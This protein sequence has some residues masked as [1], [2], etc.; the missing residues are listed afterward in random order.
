MGERGNWSGENRKQKLMKQS[1]TTWMTTCLESLPNGR[2]L[3]REQVLWEE[4]WTKWEQC[5]VIKIKGI[6]AF[7]GKQCSKQWIH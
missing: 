5:H 6:K 3:K 4:T 7:E 1:F 2:K